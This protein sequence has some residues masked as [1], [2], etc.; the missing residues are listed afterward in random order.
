MDGFEKVIICGLIC[1]TV[2]FYID[3]NKEHMDRMNRIEELKELKDIKSG[4]ELKIYLKEIDS[5]VNVVDSQS[6]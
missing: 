2:I 4:I 1:L 3:S 6:F 5:I